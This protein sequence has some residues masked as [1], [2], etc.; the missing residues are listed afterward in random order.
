LDKLQVLI[1]DDDKE[2]ARFFRTVLNFMDLDVE[3]VL[4]GREALIKLSAMVPDLI[5]LD[6]QLGAEIGGEDIL[7][8]IRSNPRFDHTRVIVITGHPNSTDLVTNLADLI[9]I[10]PVEVDLLRT[11]ITRLSSFGFEPKRLP[12]RDPV[13]LLFNKEF[14]Y[15]RLD[16]AFERAK[17]REE[18]KFAVLV[19]RVIIAGET[20]LSISASILDVIL[21]EVANRLHRYL[22]PTDTVARLLGWKFVILNEDLAKTEDV[23][24]IIQRVRQMLADPIQVGEESYTVTV[25][26]GAVVND[27]RFKQPKEIFE[28]AER[29]LEKSEAVV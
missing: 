21:R 2:T 6:M 13:T 4:T 23:S 3:T 24:I 9:L 18:F 8:Q 17:R 5:L 20:E 7:Y 15:T 16:L 25:G 27:R 29:A 22:R 11:L 26:V 14:F 28:A 19:L 1:I 12:F 10:K